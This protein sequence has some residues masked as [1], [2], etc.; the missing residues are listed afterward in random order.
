MRKLEIKGEIRSTFTLGVAKFLA[1]KYHIDV[2]KRAEEYDFENLSG[3]GV[4][5]WKQFKKRGMF[6]ND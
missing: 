3:F 5:E 6:P 1:E 2:D 4:K